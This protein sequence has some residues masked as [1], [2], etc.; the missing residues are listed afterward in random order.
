MGED[1]LE[2]ETEFA[3]DRPPATC[4]ALYVAQDGLVS[5]GTKDLTRRVD[6]SWERIV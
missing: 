1:G 3:D 4:H 6:D 2:Q 5:M